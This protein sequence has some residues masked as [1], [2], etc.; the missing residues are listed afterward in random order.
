MYR[1]LPLFLLLT[2]CQQQVEYIEKTLPN[3]EL[4]TSSID[5]G[6]IQ[7][8]TAS[9]KNFYIENQG[10]LPMGLHS[11]YI[12]AEG[13][14]SNFSI[15]YNPSNVDCPDD[16]S[17]YAID[18]EG[19]YHLDA[20]D[21][22][23]NPGCSIAATVSYN[24]L[25]MGEA[26]A[27]ITIT[28]FIEPEEFEDSTIP[29]PRFY[30]DPSNF[31]QKILLHGYSNLGEGNIVVTP[32]VVDFGH[33]WTGESVTQQIMINN[34]GDGD[35]M[36]QNP[37]LNENCDEAFSIDISAIDPDRVIPAAEGTI[38]EA[39]FTPL[40]LEAAVCTVFVPS[41][42]AETDLLEIRLKA[43][44][45]IDPT[46]TPPVVT[47]ISPAIGYQHDGIDRLSKD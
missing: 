28:S 19:E 40:D 35:L 45:G 13:F 12:E 38:F 5:F 33:H 30:R 9:T 34:V 24:P 8:G 16:P 46:N 15:N 11:L 31:T 4:S 20:Q 21:T 27:A 43:N 18:E 22:F 36:I 1:S 29:A 3:M 39:T 14:E 6:T 2:A 37:Y 7:W 17:E 23:L 32:R 26:Y 42:D 47:M 41:D 25:I 10:D 44:D